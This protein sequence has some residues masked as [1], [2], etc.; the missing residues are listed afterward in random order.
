MEDLSG[1]LIE[2]EPFYLP[3][4]REM[5]IFRAAARAR[6]PVMLKGPTGCGKTRFLAR[7]AFE[8][9]RPLIT[10]ACHEDL[11]GPDLVGRHLFVGGETRW[12]DGP[13]ALAVRQ[14]G[15]CYLDEIVEARQDCLVILHPLLDERR[16][17]VVEKLGQVLKAA[18]DFLLAVSYNPGY[19]SA[20]K[21]LKISTAQRF[22]ALDFDYPNQEAEVQIVSQEAG[23]KPDLAQSLVQAGQRIRRLK[24][25]GLAE[26]ASTRL[27]IYAG[28]LTRRG[29]SP[30][31]AAHVCLRNPLT[32][33][34]DLREAVSGVIADVF[35]Q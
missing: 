9:K 1:F 35:P 27:L 5:D 23:V 18:D 13:L 7:M 11:T 10:V 24:E 2:Q 26:G 4:G 31:E 3:Q 17:L 16:I 21:D 34:A 15:I 33:D 19:Q 22:V 28:Q 6:L 12:L 14:G 30:A 25:V 8:L 20:L 29:L 32:D